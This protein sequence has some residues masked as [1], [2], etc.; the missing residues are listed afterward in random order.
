MF[1]NI[2]DYNYF[3]RKLLDK[4]VKMSNMAD[5]ILDF[6]EIVGSDDK[7]NKHQWDWD[8]LPDFETMIQIKKESEK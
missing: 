8:N 7:Y 4:E 3:N 2:Y 6:L 5:F 1:F